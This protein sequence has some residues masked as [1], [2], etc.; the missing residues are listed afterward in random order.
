[1]VFLRITTD[2]DFIAVR[3]AGIALASEVERRGPDAVTTSWWKEERGKRV[4][5][6]FNQ[7]ARD[8]TFASAYSV[9]RTAIATVS[10][11]LTW[12]EL[13]S[14]NP[15]DYT[16]ATVADLAARRDDPWADIDSIDQSI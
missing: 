1:H 14:A 8:R 9:R 12:D 3:R 10:T 13:A 6:D 2:W 16:I 15:D 11:P 4:F 5:I 7:N